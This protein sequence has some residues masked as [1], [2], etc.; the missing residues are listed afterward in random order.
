MMR[1]VKLI[2]IIFFVPLVSLSTL[3]SVFGINNNSNII[4]LPN[5]NI[6]FNLNQLNQA[7]NLYIEQ[8]CPEIY[9]NRTVIHN[10][11][12]SDSPTQFP[13]LDFKIHV[14]ITVRSFLV[15]LMAVL[16]QFKPIL[17][18]LSMINRV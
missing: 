1:Y 4:T 14:L 9:Q 3:L 2:V 5:S 17:G 8:L 18:L 11:I 16:V 13:G 6:A 12:V 7:N 15:F 10:A